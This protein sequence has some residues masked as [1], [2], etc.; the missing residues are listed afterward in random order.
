[1]AKNNMTSSIVKDVMLS[2]KLYVFSPNETLE[3]VK[4]YL[5]LHTKKPLVVFYDKRSF[6]VYDY[7]RSIGEDV[8]GKGMVKEIQIAENEL[9]D[10]EAK[11]PHLAQLPQK[12]IMLRYTQARLCNDFDDIIL[13]AEKLITE[14]GKNVIVLC[15]NR[16]SIE[17][18]NG[19]RPAY[20]S[21]AEPTFDTWNERIHAFVADN[22]NKDFTYT[23]ELYLAAMGKGY[24][25]EICRY[26][27]Q[28]N[29]E[30]EEAARQLLAEAKEEL[31]TFKDEITEETSDLI[32]HQISTIQLRPGDKAK[33]PDDFNTPK[34]EMWYEEEK[35]T[36]KITNWQYDDRNWL[37]KQI[38]K[39]D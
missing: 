14:S 17:K 37:T 5:L 32:R 10:Y 4:G 18:D 26:L 13:L 12:A 27:N 33:L 11:I 9:T 1:M 8:L 35:A 16:N 15:D 29:E 19:G 39:E 38:L 34:T 6:P 24:I 20:I 22:E 21:N 2:E 28:D 31:S 23:K 36:G 30:D 3:V 25:D 7:I